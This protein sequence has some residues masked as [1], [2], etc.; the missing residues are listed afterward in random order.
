[1][2]APHRRGRN[3]GLIV[4]VF[5]IDLGLATAGLLLLQRGLVRDDEVPVAHAGGTP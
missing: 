1:V 5:L 2:S 4:F 3:W